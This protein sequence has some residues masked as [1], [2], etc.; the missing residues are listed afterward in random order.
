M[1]NLAKNNEKIEFMIHKENE[2]LVNKWM[3]PNFIK[4]L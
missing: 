3:D 4:N 2:E 1:L